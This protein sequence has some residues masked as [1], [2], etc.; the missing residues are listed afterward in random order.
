MT[1]SGAGASA[2]PVDDPIVLEQ[3]I[4][5]RA[6][7]EQRRARMRRTGRQVV[8]LAVFV[9]LLGLSYSAYKVVGS[10]IDDA[11]ADW[12]IVGSILPESDNLRMPPVLDIVAGI[13]EEPRGTNEPFWSIVGKEAAFTLREAAV[14]FAVGVV[15]G[16]GIAIVLTTSGRLERALVP[17]VIASQTH[18]VDRHR[19][20]HRD[21]G[22]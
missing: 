6:A 18:P 10:A 17:H 11:Q 15:V 8:V 9:C 1:D 2:A 19:A 20:H 7:R 21:L 13:F 22:P 3:L 4:R 5:L 14:G 12:P 16:L